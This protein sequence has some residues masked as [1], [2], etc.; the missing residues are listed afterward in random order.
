[1]TTTGVTYDAGEVSQ[2]EAE[3]M[4]SKLEAEGIISKFPE[5]EKRFFI[6]V[7]F[8]KKHGGQGVRKVV[9]FILLNAYSRVWK[10]NFP[11][12]L[13]TVRKIHADWS[14]FTTSDLAQGY[15]HIPFCGVL[16]KLF[17]F[18]AASQRF[19]YNCLPQGW[20]HSDATFHSR[21]CNA[22]IDTH[23]VVYVDDIFVGGRTKEEHHRNLGQVFKRLAEMG[24]HVNM[25]KVQLGKSKVIY[26]VYD[27]WV[28]GCD[29][30]TYI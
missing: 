15:F 21:L 25:S 7:M 10:T 12:T 16:Q 23:V 28:G 2:R 5:E 13:A 20:S 14:L 24:M 8:L 27:V 11:G 3:A 19:R 30:E 4:V 18:E 29:L 6:Q 17:T 9:D 1:M 22:L 26:L